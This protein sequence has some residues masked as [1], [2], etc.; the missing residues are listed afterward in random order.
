MHC[1]S[2]CSYSRKRGHPSAI[3][4]KLVKHINVCTQSSRYRRVIDRTEQR[5]D[6]SR[7]FCVR[8]SALFDSILTM[9]AS[10]PSRRSSLLIIPR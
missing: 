4:L 7:D 9:S 6:Y 10:A 8:E 1:G 2:G 3:S 5:V